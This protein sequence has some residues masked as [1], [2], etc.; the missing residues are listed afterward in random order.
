MIR[1][2]FSNPNITGRLMIVLLF[3]GGI[4]YAGAFDGF[5][6]ETEASNCCGG[7]DAEHFSSSS[8]CNDAENNVTCQKRGNGGAPKYCKL[9]DGTQ[10]AHKCSNAKKCNINGCNG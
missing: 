6:V 3:V 7:A 10:C 8:S 2:F 5:V 9:S 1:N 4:V